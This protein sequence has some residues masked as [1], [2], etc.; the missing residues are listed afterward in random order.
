MCKKLLTF[1]TVVFLSFVWIS[2]ASVKQA[3]SN[4][5]ADMLAGSDKN[6]KPVKK[7]PDN[8]MSAITGESDTVLMGDFFPTALKMYEVMQ[9]GN[10]EHAGLA[11]MCGEMN[12]MYANAFI[13]ASADRLTDA[14][15]DKKNAEYTRAKLHYLRGRDYILTMFEKKYPGFKKAMLSSDE[16]AIQAAAAKLKLC[17]VTAAYWCAGGALGAFSLDPLNADLLN[18]VR[19]PVAM[20]EKA[21]ALDPDY[22]EGVIWDM[23]TAFYVSA[24]ADFG[25]DY[26]RGLYCHEQAMRVSGGR[27]P[28]PYITYAVSVCQPKNDEQ[29]FVDALNKA[30]AIQPDDNP[31]ERLSTIIFQQKAKFLLDSKD[32]YFVHW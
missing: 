17:D 8:S 21:A 16:D 28:G 29:G 26:D 6:G 3:G 25:G 18:S 24:P 7:S 15:F 2:C 30:L 10:P 22:S 31:D 1:I 20:L 13:Q 9:A 11:I 14:E 4:A 19:G 12:V 5:V 27:T 23:L 32:D